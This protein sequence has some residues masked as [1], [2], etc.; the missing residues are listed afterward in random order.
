[1]INSCIHAYNFSFASRNPSK[2]G[3]QQKFNMVPII[4]KQ[5]PIGPFILHKMYMVKVMSTFKL[6]IFLSWKT[7][8]EFSTA[9]VTNMFFLCSLEPSTSTEPFYQLYTVINND[10]MLVSNPSEQLLTYFKG[11]DGCMYVSL[12]DSKEIVEEGIVDDPLGTILQ[13][14]DSE[15]E[16]VVQNNVDLSDVDMQL[17]TLDN[18]QI[19][20]TTNDYLRKHSCV[21]LTFKTF[22]F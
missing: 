21:L 9:L 16:Q 7:T 20:L 15:S 6:P 18:G 1:M 5:W 11:D 12:S 2:F 10:T 13:L 4:N 14:E 8:R 3:K 22:R 17:I 19:Y